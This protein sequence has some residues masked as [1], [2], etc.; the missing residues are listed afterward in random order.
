M[1]AAN[2]YVQ[3]QMIN[4]FKVITANRRVVKGRIDNALI[5][6]VVFRDL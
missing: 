4:H 2:N 6:H 3:K 1:I 5:A